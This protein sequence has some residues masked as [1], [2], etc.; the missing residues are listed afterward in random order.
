MKSKRYSCR[1]YDYSSMQKMGAERFRPAPIVLRMFRFRYK[2]SAS[3]ARGFRPSRWNC[4]PSQDQTWSC[5]RG[6]HRT[7]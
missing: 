1:R 6:F 5:N 2:Y 7:G 3:A 4:R